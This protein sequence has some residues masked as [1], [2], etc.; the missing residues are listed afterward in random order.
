M[1]QHLV[2][3]QMHFLG[4]VLLSALCVWFSSVT[5]VWQGRYLQN[6]ELENCMKCCFSVESCRIDI[7]LNRLSALPFGQDNAVSAVFAPL[8]MFGYHSV[9]LTV[10]DPQ[11]QVWHRC[12]CR[13]GQVQCFQ[14]L[15][16]CLNNVYQR[17]MKHVF[18]K[19]GQSLPV[20]LK[21]CPDY[22]C[23]WLGASAPGGPWESAWLVPEA[24]QAPKVS[25]NVEFVPLKKYTCW[26]CICEG[27]GIGIYVSLSKVDAHVYRST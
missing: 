2:A 25:R 14:Y 13:H 3:L 20:D 8:V 11:R 22:T 16:H 12:C 10:P 24:P 23:D 1:L 18:L 4:F 5:A 17:Q 6:V 19:Q 21:S 9:R 7:F 15:A 27:F 26:R